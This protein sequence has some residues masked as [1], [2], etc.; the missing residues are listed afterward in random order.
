LRYYFQKETKNVVKP[1]Y[2][3]AGQDIPKLES[4][5]HDSSVIELIVSQDTSFGYY[6]GENLIAEDPHMHFQC[7]VLLLDRAVFHLCLP[8]KQSFRWFNKKE[9]DARQNRHGDYDSEEKLELIEIDM[10]TEEGDGLF[11]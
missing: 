6:N 7:R 9:N 1:E 11:Y 5:L 3:A 8:R 2:G 4:S 10:E